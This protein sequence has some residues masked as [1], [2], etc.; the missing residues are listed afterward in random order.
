MSSGMGMGVGGGDRRQNNSLRTGWV[1]GS[2]NSYPL[3]AANM[4]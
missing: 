2:C 4:C 3:Y 1:A